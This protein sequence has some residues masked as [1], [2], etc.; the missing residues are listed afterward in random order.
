M[1]RER[2]TA[3]AEERPAAEHLLVCNSTQ[4]FVCGRQRGKGSGPGG[5]ENFVGD[6][7]EEKESYFLM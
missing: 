4:L 7:A 3:P 6:A 1:G 5:G 2:K